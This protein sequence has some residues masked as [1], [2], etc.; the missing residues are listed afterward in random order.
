MRIDHIHIRNFRKLKNCRIDFNIDQTIFVGANNSGKTSAMSAIIW[1]LKDQNRFT[2]RE[3]TLTNWRDINKLANSWVAVDDETENRDALL[4]S[5]LS[6]EQWDNLVPSLDLWINVDEKEAYM[7]YKLIP[8]LEWKKDLVGVR[9]R[10]EPKDIKS[11]YADF[12]TASLKVKEIKE[13]PQY[14]DAN[15]VD[16]F[17]QN[18]WDFLNRRGNLNKY[19]EIKYYVLDSQNI[20]YE[21]PDCN[22]QATPS[23]SLENNPLVSLIKIDSI[24]A[25]REFSDPEGRNDNEIDTLSKQLQA[26]YRSNFED[27]TQFDLDDLKL[28]GEMKRATE[29]YDEKLDKSFRAP[30]AELNNINYPGFQNP[31]I[32]V[33]SHVS[34]VDSITHESSV[35]FT[36]QGDDE[37]SLPEKYNGLGLRNLISIYLKM[38]QF[39]EQ[40]T[41]LDRIEKAGINQIE[42]IHLVFIEEP[43]AH[44]HAQAQQVFIRKAMD[45]LT[46]DSAN[47][48]LRNNKNLTT[49][50]VV[51]THSNHIVN[52]VDMCHLRYFKRIIDDHIKIPVSE[53]VNLSRT[54]GDD[55]DTKR[56]V[57]RYIRL[58]HCDIFF[59]DAIILVEGAAER[60]LM[61][62]FIRDENM[63]NFY[64]SVIEINGSHAHRFDSLTQKLG[65]PTLIITDIDA[66]EERLEKEEL[67]WK[68]AIP[69]KNK[70]QKTNN[71]TI[72]HWL[73]IESI[74]MLLE[75]PFPN[76]QKGNICISYQ[77]PISVNWTN[78]KKED[79]LY[80]V[81]PYTFEDSLVFTNIKLFQRD[82]KMAKMGVITTFY[83]YLKKTI[84]LEDFHEKMFSCLEKRKNVKASFATDILYTEQFDKIQAPSYIKEGLIWL[85]KCLNNKIRK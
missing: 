50:L 35:Q 47:E 84:S 56:F 42:P 10:F 6:P 22:V 39:R 38:V 33:K 65:I 15:N 11:L 61:P 59:A 70:K 32:H 74:D 20:D 17:P 83:N 48:I 16:L 76:K 4:A 14:K 71:D 63:D 18:M 67:K 41:N 2:T 60:I 36:V 64:I 55:N 34:I 52:E 53:V 26:Y 80:E 62:K 23:I 81:Y 44:L 75:L 66:Q 25:F 57:T 37:L 45:A 27:E 51:S 21:N 78:Q 3:F 30:I 72:K 54:F 5:L 31:E 58:T 46:N 68:S 77:I 85:Q 7:V 40:W 12:R 9:L 82:E 13:S 73:K 43:E 8:S 28:L 49:Q 19:F 1:F 24:E 69:Q 29:T 79:E